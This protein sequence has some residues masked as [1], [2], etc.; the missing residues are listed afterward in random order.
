MDWNRVDEM[1]MKYLH[2]G[3][4]VFLFLLM[5]AC[6]KK[7]I[8]DI[9][10]EE[11]PQL[12]ATGKF[13]DIPFEFIAGQNSCIGETFIIE[14]EEQGVRFWVFEFSVP[15]VNSVEKLTFSLI[16]EIPVTEPNG[17]TPNDILTNQDELIFSEG[18]SMFAVPSVSISYSPTGES[19][20]HSNISEQNAESYFQFSDPVE[21]TVNGEQFLMTEITF[22]C[23]LVDDVS[24]EVLQLNEGRGTIAFR[25]QN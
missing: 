2:I 6:E 14:D 3:T 10:I 22:A 23:E 18:D 9:V 15:T 21:V 24:S 20:W 11:E 16:E 5:S 4:L 19:S 7:E 25:I 13:N 8:D 12:M 17:P 1:I